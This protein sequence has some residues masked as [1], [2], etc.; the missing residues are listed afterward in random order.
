[1]NL[2]IKLNKITKIDENNDGKIIDITVKET[3]KMVMM[4]IKFEIFDMK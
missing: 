4:P 3:K 2:V 1:M